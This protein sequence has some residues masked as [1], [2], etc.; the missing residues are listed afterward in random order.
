VSDEV[1]WVREYV[2][3]EGDEEWAGVGG[4]SGGDVVACGRAEVLVS[5]EV[6]QAVKVRN[7]HVVPCRD[8]DDACFG[9]VVGWAGPFLNLDLDDGTTVTVE[10]GL[11]EGC[12][13]IINEEPS[14]FVCLRCGADVTQGVAAWGRCKV[15]GLSVKPE[16][17]GEELW[18]WSDG[19]DPKGGEWREVPRA[20]LFVESWEEDA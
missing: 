8:D 15:C 16:R 13:E 4:G 2:V 18:T 11:P 17:D 19:P 20:L 12:L 1:E 3:P 14:T 10:S 5:F 7:G 9:V 6:G